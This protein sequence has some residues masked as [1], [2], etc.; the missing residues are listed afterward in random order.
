MRIKT[1]DAMVGIWQPQSD[2]PDAMFLEV[3]AD[4]TCRQSY[5]LDGLAE[6]PQAEGTCQFEG[7]VL[8]YTTLQLSGVQPCPSPTAEYEVRS[9][10]EG[11]IQLVASKETCARRRN[12]TQHLYRR[13]P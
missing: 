7:D 9:I 5:S 3:L 6:S 1:V 2:S 12:S 11:Q 8:V 4:G 10:A 13:V